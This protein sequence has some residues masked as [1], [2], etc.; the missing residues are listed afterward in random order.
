MAALSDHLGAE[1]SA[2][3]LKNFDR[4]Y[5][6]KSGQSALQQMQTQLPRP[7]PHDLEKAD[8]SA[9]QSLPPRRQV[10]GNVAES[11]QR[12]AVDVFELVCESD[13]P[14]PRPKF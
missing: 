8:L 6:Q 9:Y 12:T 3:A 14:D 10:W 1:K 2:E 11:L 7:L 5:P 4:L 13:T